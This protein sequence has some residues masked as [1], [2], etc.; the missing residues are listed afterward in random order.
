MSNHLNKTFNQSL[1]MT[2]TAGVPLLSSFALGGSI[3]RKSKWSNQA[4]QPHVQL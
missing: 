3:L 2:V 4:V 1:L